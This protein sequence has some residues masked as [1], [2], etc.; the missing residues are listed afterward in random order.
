MLLLTSC[1]NFLK[2]NQ[3]KSEIEESIEIANSSPI[4]YHI[5]ADK[6]SGTVSPSQATLKKKQ[7]VNLLFTPAEGWNFICWEALDR[8][9]GE[10]L[11][12]A[13]KFENPQKLETKATILNPRQN[14]MIHPKC[15]LVPKVIDISPRFDNSGCDQDR[16]IEITFNKALDTQIF[17]FSTI[18]ITT[19][20][21]T[22]LFSTDPDASFFDSPYFSSDNKVLNIPTI[23]GKFLL[24]PDG[25]DEDTTPH[26]SKKSTDDITI[27][28]DLSSV[29]D[30][31]G[32]QIEEF[33]PYT[34]RVNKNVDNVPPVITDIH[35]YSTSDTSDYFYKELTQKAYNNWSETSSIKRPNNLSMFKKG[36]YSRN[37]VSHLYMN[38][39]GYDDA[40]EIG[41]IRVKETYKRNKDNFEITPEM[42]TFRDFGI[43]DFIVEDLEEDE[44]ED[45]DYKLYKLEY[46]FDSR[47]TDDGLYLIEVSLLDK[48][49]NES[50]LESYWV[51]KDTVANP[52]CSINEASKTENKKKNAIRVPTYNS[53]NNIYESDINLGGVS[54]IAGKYWIILNRT[55][56]FFRDWISN[57][58]V[59]VFLEEENSEDVLTYENYSI[60]SSDPYFGNKISQAMQDKN[61]HFNSYKTTIIKIQ[62]E[63]ESGIVTE[64][65][66]TLLKSVDVIGFTPTGAICN[67]SDEFYEGDEITYQTVWTYQADEDSTPGDYHL[68]TSNTLWFIS[69]NGIYNIYIIRKCGLF[70]SALG[71]PMKYYKGVSNP[72]TPPDVIFPQIKKRPV[73]EDG[74]IVYERNSEKAKFNL[75]LAYSENTSTNYSYSVYLRNTYDTNKGYYFNGSENNPKLF[76]VEVPSDEEYQIYLFATDSDGNV[77]KQSGPML[78]NNNCLSLKD[79]DNK[80]PLISSLFPVWNST[81]SWNYYIE[82]NAF[83]SLNVSIADYINNTSHQLSEFYYYY[84]PAN[85]HGNLE[86]V[87]SKYPG[88]KLA[89]TS[90]DIANDYVNIPF[91]DLNFGTYAFYTLAYDESGNYTFK[92][93]S[94]SVTYYT[95]ATVPVLNAQSNK[96]KISSSP[97]TEA[98][99]QG[100]N[101]KIDNYER[102]LNIFTLQNG[103]WVEIKIHEK[104]TE[105]IPEPE[106]TA[107]ELWD[108]ELDYPETG[109]FI[110]I[111]GL[112]CTYNNNNGWTPQDPISMKP[113]YAYTG[114]YQYLAGGGSANAY[115]KSKSWMPMANGWQIFADKPAFVH[116]LYCSKNLTR[117]GNF[118]TAE[119]AL[120]WETRAQETGLVYN[121]G[122]GI[123]FS[124]TDE[125]LE[126]VPED[127][128]YTTIC[129]FADGTVVM[130]E[131]KQK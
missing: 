46:D 26:N 20:E 22:E 108:Y 98:I 115:C 130:S 117:T 37:H 40:S 14:L 96:I 83:R 38:I 51:I 24:L 44:E 103:K 21:G 12:D 93:A 126:G 17:D 2:A 8:T 56:S 6:D 23:K 110:K 94:G 13:I 55:D 90:D 18:S 28:I 111:C 120:E 5:I 127:Y 30:I 54:D 129:H 113:A 92:R 118:T 58:I 64:E 62:I 39:Y 66:I 107:N 82:S 4:L 41:T 79:E 60:D 61:I 89:I 119:A 80:P 124:Y 74:D 33:A 42:T 27:R 71:K 19:P 88:K 72:V 49:S 67:I 122:R 81:D 131:V 77:V 34:Y 25:A 68:E 7:S 73:Y 87:S 35:L 53:T 59:K 114:Y 16:T 99:C 109:S 86:E 101:V 75:E 52:G 48:A 32:L 102:Y 45:Y 128:Y 43:N 121:D 112:Y 11:P 50:L 57:R 84:V 36:D 15:N 65:T 76:E 78:D 104:A 69:S 123:T 31:D 70:Y 116:T 10:L 29:K 9:T 106:S 47:N 85:F 63:E 97:L 105:E 91:D 95:A 100:F 125:N 1:E 3:V